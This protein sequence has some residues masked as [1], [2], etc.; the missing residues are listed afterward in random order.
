MDTGADEAERRGLDDVVL[1]GGVFQNRLLLEGVVPALSARGLRPLLPLR[2]PANDGAIA[3]GQA[4]IAAH[5]ATSIDR[6]PVAR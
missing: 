4:A 1:S 2:L 5:A 3:Y 6:G